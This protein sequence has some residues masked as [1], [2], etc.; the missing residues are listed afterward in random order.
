MNPL[1]F[2][3]D[4]IKRLFAKS[5]KFF[6]YLQW[7]GIIGSII[8]ALP[9]FLKQFD[10][11]IDILSEPWKTIVAV[12]SVTTFIVSKLTVSDDSTKKEDIKTN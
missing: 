10:V 5:P 7:A 9:E 3:K 2:I 12:A 11:H 6:V 8:V 1:D 4:F